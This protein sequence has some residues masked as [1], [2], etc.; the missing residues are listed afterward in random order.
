VAITEQDRIR[1]YQFFE[2][3]MGEEL[4]TTMMD[5]LPPT[6]WG[7]LATKDDIASVRQDLE[8]LRLATKDDIA[9]V[10]QELHSLR[11]TTEKDMRHYWQLA[12]VRFDS[13]ATKAELLDLKAEIHRALRLQFGALVMVMVVAIS[14]LGRIP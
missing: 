7:D 8:Q 14:T 12:E 9:L 11:T 13:M 5:C 4:A 3:T 6:G 2:E 10:R 1:L